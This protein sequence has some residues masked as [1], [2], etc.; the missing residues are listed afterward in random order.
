MTLPLE[1]IKILD[2]SQAVLGPT[3][4]Q[5][6]G[7]LGAD[8]IKVEPLGG[9]FTRISNM[10][11]ADS[12]IFLACNRNKRSIAVNLKTPA[13]KEIV[14]E[15]AKK[16]DVII[17]NFRPGVMKR[18]GLDY[19]KISAINSKIVYLNLN[20]YGDTGPL[21]HRRGGDPWAQAFTGMVASQGSPEG[22][23]YLCGHAVID[24]GGGLIGDV[25][26]LTA[27]M[28]R[29]RAGRGQ[30]LSINMIHAGLYMQT[31]TFCYSL[32][33]GLL[34]KKGGRGTAR[35]Q[36]P[37]GAYTAK[38]GDVVTIFGQD[39]E[40]WP[41]FC[42]ILD[43]EHLLD[44]PRYETAEMR[45][46]KK[47][48]LYPIL[49]EAFRKRTRKAWMTRF[50]KFGLR[51]DPCLDYFELMDHPQFEANDMTAEVE[52]PALGPIKLLGAPIKFHGMGSIEP[53]RHPPVLGEHSKEILT[54]FGYRA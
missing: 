33:D 31:T 10:R 12:S 21:S 16:T 17:Q 41:V 19:K 4:S 52:H 30:E 26:I 54:E 45:T 43:I 15:L 25:G 38:D 50:K 22:P 20:M 11:D 32:T 47:F 29:E 24:L 6:L 27:L 40:E 28:E 13:G 5:L 2:F 3:C 51:C 14:L 46:E 39:D 48:E 42:H 7:D 53:R 1:A 37:Y 49:D 34:L 8:V 35:G 36:F 44:D 23:P 9:D 18:L